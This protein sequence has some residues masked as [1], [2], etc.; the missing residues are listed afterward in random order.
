MSGPAW[1]MRHYERQRTPL[2][3]LHFGPTQP[4]EW[5]W[6]ELVPTLRVG[7]PSR[8]LCVLWCSRGRKDDAERRRLHSHAERGNE[9][10]VG[11][12]MA[13][14]TLRM[15]KTCDS[16]CLCHLPF[17]VCHLPF[18]ICHLP[19]CLQQAHGD[20]TIGS[21]SPPLGFCW[22]GAILATGLTVSTRPVGRQERAFRPGQHQD[23]P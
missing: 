1:Q 2:V 23:E 10:G 3:D 4:L 19:C 14:E 17:S 13:N 9:G 22:M 8:T 11:S 21:D 16:G 6:P 7:M 18:S 20:G 12:S 15:A 5:Q